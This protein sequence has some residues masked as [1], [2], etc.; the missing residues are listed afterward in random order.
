MRIDNHN[1]EKIARLKIFF[2]KKNHDLRISYNI[3]SPY[4]SFRSEEAEIDL[5]TIEGLALSTFLVK[6]NLTTKWS[7]EGFIWGSK[8]ENGTFN[9]VVGR[10]TVVFLNNK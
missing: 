2:T 7:Y 8:D 9:G 4:F 10:V 3:V 6:Y 5:E 1:C